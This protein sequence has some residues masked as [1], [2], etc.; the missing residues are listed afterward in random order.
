MIIVKLMDYSELDH[1]W[2]ATRLCQYIIFVYLLVYGGLD[3][4]RIIIIPVHNFHLF[5][6]L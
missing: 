4:Q 3:L 2:I 5:R 1:F 6:E